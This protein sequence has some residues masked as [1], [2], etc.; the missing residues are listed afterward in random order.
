M[1]NRNK[2]II[3]AVAVVACGMVLCVGIRA[4]LRSYGPNKILKRPEFRERISVRPKQITLSTPTK[5]HSVNLG[6][7]S[8]DTGSKGPISIQTSES[9]ASL[10]LT[11]GKVYMAFLPP[12]CPK[13]PTNTVSF[14]GIS[15]HE[16]HIHPHTSAFLETFESDSIAGQM[17]VEETE[18]LP[19]T[20]AFFMNGD[21]FLL[22]SIKLRQKG[23]D[24]IGNK[25]VQ[26][27]ES[28]DL[29]G[30]VRIGRRN[31]G[32]QFAHVSFVSQDGKKA[33]G[34]ILSLDEGSTNEIS[35]VLAPILSS[36]HFTV[37]S[38]SNRERIKAL[39][40]EAGID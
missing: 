19:F 14:S 15:A 39:I 26:F 40:R 6:Y 17:I 38:V 33:V 2:L 9:G 18:I 22:Y 34:L 31:V 36:F 5:V 16:K 21:D 7:A 8:F 37:D 11:N 3:I 27:F 13:E 12:F 32:R 23:S 20:K 25:E 29:K 1:S 30:I 10:I 24:G 35:K 28:N 4:T